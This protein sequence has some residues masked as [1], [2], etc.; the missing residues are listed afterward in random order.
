MAWLVAYHQITRPKRVGRSRVHVDG[1]V[2]LFEFK[3]GLGALTT[4][5]ESAG[6]LTGRL[7]TTTAERAFFHSLQ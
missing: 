5:A 3:I 4:D 1:I 7:L 6:V 2:S